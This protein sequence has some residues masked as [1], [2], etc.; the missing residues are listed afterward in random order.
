MSKKKEFKFWHGGTPPGDQKAQLELAVL[1]AISRKQPYTSVRDKYNISLANIYHIIERLR[2]SK[3]IKFSEEGKYEVIASRYTHLCD[4][5]FKN[6]YDLA[7]EHIDTDLVRFDDMKTT[8]FGYEFNS[9]TVIRYAKRSSP[10]NEFG[11]SAWRA[12]QRPSENPTDKEWAKTIVDGFAS[13]VAYVRGAVERQ[14]R[15]E[16]EC[17]ER[18]ERLRN[19]GLYVI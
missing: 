18:E 2:R 8:Y 3:I 13:E 4:E 5:R 17:A 11:L 14:Q 16:K 1:F 10:D 19:P 12:I 9:R 6:I 15:Y 7:S